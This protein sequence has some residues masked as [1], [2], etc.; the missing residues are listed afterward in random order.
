MQT[1]KVFPSSTNDHAPITLRGLLLLAAFLLMLGSR[2]PGVDAIRGTDLPLDREIGQRLSN[3][4]LKDAVSRRDVTL[5]GFAGKKAVVLVF[6]GTDCPLA[7]LYAPR[8]VELNRAY[9]SR[10]ASGHIRPWVRP[11]CKLTCNSV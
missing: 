6:L 8:L 9:R 1:A 11:S 5:Y 3:F 4:T 2:A 7:N 10:G